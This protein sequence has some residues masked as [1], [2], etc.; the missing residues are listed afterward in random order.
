MIFLDTSV[1]VAGILETHPHHERS[2]SL[3]ERGSRSSHAFVSVHS[4]AECY[5][6]LSVTPMHPMIHPEY[7]LQLIRENVLAHFEPVELVQKDY[8]TAL[9]RVA[10]L[11]F[12]SGAIY[13]A[14]I[15][16]AAVKKRVETFYTWNLDDFRRFSDGKIPVREP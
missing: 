16:Q 7:A 14:L 11:G 6:T 10:H 12:R 2:L 15:W 5:A 4:L 1:L 9:E 8:E 13:D 3:M